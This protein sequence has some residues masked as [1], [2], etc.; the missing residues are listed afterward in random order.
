MA[1]T[2]DDYLEHIGLREYAP[3]FRA[4]GV[5][6]LELLKG[7]D[8]PAGA[9]T[10]TGIQD[11]I[12]GRSS[13][14]KAGSEG[15]AHGGAEATHGAADK[16]APGAALPGLASSPLAAQHVGKITAQDIQAW[17][18]AE[19]R[20]ASQ[21]WRGDPEAETRHK[22]LQDAIKEAND[23]RA[24]CE[25]ATKENRETVLKDAASKLESLYAEFKSLGMGTPPS[26]EALD[27]HLH[28]E[29]AALEK[30]LSGLSQL[31]EAAI[32]QREMTA[33][34]L[35][36]ANQLL[37]GHC[38]DANGLTEAPGGAVLAM[39][40]RS[41]DAELFGPG[42]E[43]LDFGSSYRSESAMMRAERLL[44]T[45]GSSLS[46]S[47]QASG[48]FFTGTGIGA[49][50]ASAR[51]AQAQEERH[52]RFTQ[53]S[54]TFATEIQ[55]RHHWSPM[56][57]IVFSTLQFELSVEAMS[58]LRTLLSITKEAERQ[59]S[60]VAF[61]KQF[62][63]HV[64]GRVTLGGWYKYTAKTTAKGIKQIENMVDAVSKVM[65]WAASVSAT[66]AG[67][68]GA[69][70]F[71][72]AAEGKVSNTRVSGLQL[73]KTE[74]ELDVSIVTS[75]LGGIDGLP[76]EVWIGSIQYSPQWR[77][78]QRSA[79]Y[80]IWKI[81]E[82]ISPSGFGTPDTQAGGTARSGA[83]ARQAELRKL[84]KLLEKVWV[85]DIFAPSFPDA[86]VKLR[87]LL[88]TRDIETS[89]QLERFLAVELP[90]LQ[91]PETAVAW[92]AASSIPIDRDRF[93]AG[94]PS[95]TVFR[96]QLICL[97]TGERRSSAHRPEPFAY[98]YDGTDWGESAEFT[99]MLL[100]SRG[101]GVVPSANKVAT[102]L[103]RTTARKE[104]AT[105]VFSV[106]AELQLAS[107]SAAAADTQTFA[108]GEY[109]H[110]EAGRDWPPDSA[111]VTFLGQ[112]FLVTT[113]K[114]QLIHLYPLDAQ[115]KPIV[116]KAT[117]IAAVPAA[118]KAASPTPAP[119][120]SWQALT[121]TRIAAL[122]FRKTLFCAYRDQES[123]QL[124]L[125][126]SSDALH[127][128]Q[129]IKLPGNG[130]PHGPSLAAFNGPGGPLLYC[131][132]C[133]LGPEA[134]LYVMSS[135][136][137]L[138]WHRPVKVHD[139]LAE[140]A[141][142]QQH[143]Q[144]DSANEDGPAQAAAAQRFIGLA[145]APALVVYADMEAVSLFCFYR[146]SD[147]ISYVRYPDYRFEP[148]SL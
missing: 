136:D 139:V 104:G 23:I 28:L 135:A 25:N 72:S 87:D 16:H 65:D 14:T 61:M 81:V 27:Q 47:A 20:S 115:G 90:K 77:V 8:S 91:N 5:T 120:A 15:A 6:S 70:K 102:L 26:I 98:V 50:S 109:L 85:Q 100:S 145:G 68:G 106:K 69:A 17:I 142:M 60:A 30:A 64:F 141:A 84:A 125:T 88:L 82:R 54:A 124:M 95:V 116:E 128:T 143:V 101:L 59:D 43:A 38:L 140:Q 1:K 113:D 18:D 35:I 131:A 10:R 86:S 7:L 133:G 76:R 19:G 56:R 132:Y 107:P 93:P 51:Y 122:V 111:V 71:A 46:V 2:L 103:Q 41:S 37:R 89:E 78:I 62:G 144:D 94:D 121:R 118:E 119:A 110:S 33:V 138:N 22:K 130:S 36:Y 11:E 52:E 126:M 34:E 99:P 112:T 31:T 108:L 63:S 39:P 117:P 83:S 137:G 32:K 45:H 127:W 79:P 129:P 58:E 3:V 53:G 73:T 66:Y 147:T 114:A 97:F 80:P 29:F 134:P 57:Q 49:M 12:A 96:N 44:E 13:A 67:L 48:A 40:K 4:H 74:D 24:A 148:T 123:G 9:D 146:T 105:P 92:S 55:T 42:L 75:T 21:P